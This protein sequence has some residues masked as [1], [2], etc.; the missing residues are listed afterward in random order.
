MWLSF[1]VVQVLLYSAYSITAKKAN[2]VFEMIR[3]V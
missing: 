1:K 2:A 3:Y